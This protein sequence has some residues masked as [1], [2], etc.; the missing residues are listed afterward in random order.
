M[1]DLNDL[2]QDEGF[3]SEIINAI[4]SGIFVTDPDHNILMINKAGAQMVGK[5]CGECFDRKCYEIF[6]TPLCNTPN[7]TCRLA[8]ESQT[9]IQ[10]Q[11]VLLYN[12]QEIPL[13]YS[14]RPLRNY[15]G[16]IIGCVEN[17]IDITD[18]L[19][20]DKIIWEQKERLIK[21]R[22]EDIRHLQ[23]EIMELSTPVIEIWDG[24]LSLP[25]IGTLDSHRAKIAMEKVLEAIERHRASFVIIDIT[26]VPM[27]DSEVAGHILQTANATRLM[28]SEAI[29]TGVGPHIAQVIAQ[30]GV[31]LENLTVRGRMTDALHFAI[32][33][34]AR[35]SEQVARATTLVRGAGE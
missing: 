15:K 16:E 4:T 3:L 25:L 31:G 11:T 5:R 24:I 28:G 20:K 12:E 26:G 27:V 2:S 17:F 33:E 6:K 22:E 23:D 7:C 10:G 1:K 29:L 21:K 13:E 8:M 32:G 14:A 34:L 35:K 18:R 30:G 19:E 9:I